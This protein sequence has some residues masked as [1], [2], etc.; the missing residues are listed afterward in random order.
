MLSILF[1]KYY[2]CAYYPVTTLF[3]TNKHNNNLTFLPVLY[4]PASFFD[5]L[6]FAL[7]HFFFEKI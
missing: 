2:N 6:I 1:F 7:R 3:K 4:L 5:N